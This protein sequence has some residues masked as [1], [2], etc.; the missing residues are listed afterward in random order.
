MGLVKKFK[1]AIEI[2]KG[3]KVNYELGK[4]TGLIK[5]DRVLSSVVYSHNYGF[6]PRTLCE[7]NDPL[8]VLILMQEPVLPGCFLRA[9]A[10]RLITMI[11]QRDDKIIAVCAD[12]PVYKHYADI[13]D[14]YLIA[15]LR[16]AASAASLKTIKKMRT[17]RLQSMAS[18]HQQVLSKPSNARYVNHTA[19]VPDFGASSLVPLD[20]IQLTQGTLGYLDPEYFHTS[21]LT[22]KSDVCSFGVVLAELLMG[23]KTLSFDG[24]ER[25]KSSNILCFCCKRATSTI[26]EGKIMK[27]YNIGELKEVANLAKRCVRLKR[28]DRLTMKEVAKRCLRL[29]REDR[30]TM[31][32]VAMEL[33][34]LRVIEKH[35]W[36]KPADLSTEENEY[37]LNSSACAFSID[38]GNGC[39]STSITAGYK[40]MTKQLLKALDDGR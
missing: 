6:I 38:I 1:K 2:L 12:D 7:D 5:V 19:K 25:G 23:K 11:D 36:R 37:L 14:L 27:V 22:E 20:Q 28:E 10:I 17:K 40:S 13:K 8:D 29:K 15:F 18:Y 16:S 24:P 39:S 35:P 4:K 26:L 21:Q 3:S 30:P 31:K 32:E 9:R 33:E 34:E